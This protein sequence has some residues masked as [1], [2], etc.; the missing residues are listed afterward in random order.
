M[1]QAWKAG[2]NNVDSP[3]K[4][5]QI[6]CSGNTIKSNSRT[7]I[8]IL[9]VLCP[10]QILI[11]PYP[12]FSGSLLSISYSIIRSSL[13][14]SLSNPLPIPSMPPGD[15]QICTCLSFYLSIFCCSVLLYLPIAVYSGLLCS[16]SSHVIR[17]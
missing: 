7:E 12:G 5:R 15:Q 9:Y 4:I 2:C 8:Y 16:R 10:T 6:F 13:S 11:W 1:N 17:W 3:F 14:Y